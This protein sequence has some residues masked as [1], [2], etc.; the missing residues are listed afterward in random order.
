[1]I[2]VYDFINLLYCSHEYTFGLAV[3]D[4]DETFINEMTA[5]GACA[6]FGNKPLTNF[7]IETDT[8]VLLIIPRE[9]KNSPGRELLQT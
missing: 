9:Q 5:E 4:E 6:L 3:E 2:T 8:H 1:M 7:Q